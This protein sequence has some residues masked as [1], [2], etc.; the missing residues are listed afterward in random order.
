MS[1]TYYPWNVQTLV[2][3]LKLELSYHSDMRSLAAALQLPVPVIR[4]W[5]RGGVPTITLQQVR[6]IAHYRRWSVC[7]TLQWLELKPAHIDELVA[8]DSAG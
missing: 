5:F 8:Q 7:Q 3:W 1:T 2:S 6:H 4:D